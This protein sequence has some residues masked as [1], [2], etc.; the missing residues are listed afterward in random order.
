MLEKIEAFV[1]KSVQVAKYAALP[2]HNSDTLEA[3]IAE[4]K[5]E[6]EKLKQEAA[7]VLR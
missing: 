7:D 6:G 4:L 3:M 2:S 1:D 5:A